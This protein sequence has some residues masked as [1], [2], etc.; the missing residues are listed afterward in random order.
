MTGRF[1]VVL[2]DEHANKI[3]GCDTMLFGRYIPAYWRNVGTSLKGTLHD[4]WDKNC[5]HVTTAMRSH[6]SDMQ[7]RG[8]AILSVIE[9]NE[10]HHERS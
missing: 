10:G 1:C 5:L 2:R 4:I 8:R 7:G 9:E 6:K 3:A